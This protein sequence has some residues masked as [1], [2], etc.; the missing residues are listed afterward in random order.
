MKVLYYSK[1]PEMKTSPDHYFGE[2]GVICFAYKNGVILYAKPYKDGHYIFA[3]DKV[4]GESLVNSSH[5]T[6][7]NLV[8]HY[9]NATNRT[10][11][12]KTWIR[13]RTNPSHTK[14]NFW[15]DISEKE[16][17]NNILLL[18]KYH[19]LKRQPS[20]E[21]G[22]V[23]KEGGSKRVKINVPENIHITPIYTH[24]AIRKNIYRKLGLENKI[25]KLLNKLYESLW[26]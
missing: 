13:G 7:S 8:S 16:L 26:K 4:I 14:A 18:R 6:H 17:L 19:I 25:K 3:N 11:D 2:S 20:Y 12:K 10:E 15:G 1:K 24:H 23:S 22:L 5:M 21:L 9:A